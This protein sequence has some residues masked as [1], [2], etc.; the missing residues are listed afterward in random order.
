MIS[1]FLAWQQRVCRHLLTTTLTASLLGQSLIPAAVQAEGT[2]PYCQ[3]TAAAIAEKENLLQA[4]LS[5][6]RD[7]QKRYRAVLTQHADRLR[8]CRSKTWPQTQAL[9]IRLYPCDASPGI[10]DSVLDRI[11]NRGYNQINVEVFYNG[12]VLL[13]TNNN[14][15]AWKSVLAGSG[16]DKID[17]LAQTIRKAHDRG[18]KV[19]AWLFAM[20]FGADYVRRPDK[21][22]TMAQNG[23]GQ[24]SLTASTIAGLGIELGLGN[25]DEAFIDP[26]S[27]Q[28]RSDYSRLV[29]AIAQRHP[30]GMLFDYIRYPRGH[31]GASVAAKV[32]DLWIYGEASHKVLLQR[33]ANYQGMELIQRF[34]NRG[35]ISAEDLKDINTLY[36]KEREPSWQGLNPAN[37]SATLPIAKRVALLQAELWQLTVAHAFQGVVDFLNAAI[38]PVRQQTISLGAVFFPEGNLSVGEGFD[39]RLQAWDRFPTFL[40]W[41]PMSYGVCGNTSCI[42]SQVQRVLRQSPAKSQVRPVLAGIWQQ[43]VSNRPSLELQ[44]ADLYRT[45]P[46]LKEVSHF[47]YSWQ[48]P[49]SD[50]QRKFCSL[51]K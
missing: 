46:Y 51:R 21:Q 44:M 37:S 36:P 43:S 30:D 7:A 10:L 15:T 22:Q 48:E 40:T 13:P 23:L 39:S 14:P 27:P 26:Y 35:S 42:L 20:N 28:A 38:A 12:R 5:G 29:R 2:T 50:L 31:G 11:V 25:P 45:A 16:A 18:I 32:Q 24:N 41:H 6:K 34:M 19:Y 4:A 17:L 9:W 49:G 8:Q 3:Q 1:G 47:A 33:A